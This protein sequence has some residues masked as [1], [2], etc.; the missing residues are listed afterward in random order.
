MELAQLSDEIS[1][2]IVILR[3]QGMLDSFFDMTSALKPLDG[4]PVQDWNEVRECPIKQF[5]QVFSEQTMIT[6]PPA[7]IIQLHQE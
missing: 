5:A 1:D 4:A 6:E 2:Q 7:L 3:L